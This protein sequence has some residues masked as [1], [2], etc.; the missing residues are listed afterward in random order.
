MVD[1]ATEESRGETSRLAETLRRRRKVL[2]LTQQQLAELAGVSTRFIHELENA[3]PTV[4]L[5]R[6]MAVAQT[7]GLELS[8]QLRRTGASTEPVA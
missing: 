7:L 8:W 6:V 5:D 1:R 2:G 3:K 4:R